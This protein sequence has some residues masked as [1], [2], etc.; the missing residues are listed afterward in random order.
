MND[1]IGQRQLPGPTTFD[2]SHS[3]VLF[4]RLY[5][6]VIRAKHSRLALG[7]VSPYPQGYGDT[8]DTTL[9]I[10]SLLRA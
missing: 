1:G 6:R 4:E 2:K 8:C 7:K 5:I 10:C 9:I 3:L